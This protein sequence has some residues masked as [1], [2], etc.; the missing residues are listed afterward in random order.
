VNGLVTAWVT[1][2]VGGPMVPVALAGLAAAG[3]VLAAWPGRPV[4]ESPA[5]PRA[6]SGAPRRRLVWSVLAG[7]TGVTWI[8]GATGLVLGAALAALV[9]WWTGR[10]EPAGVR[11]A[12]ERARAELPHLVL[13]FGAALGA[14]AAPGPALEM[15]CRAF[16]GAAAARLGPV[17]AR[18]AL[19][20][21]PALVWADLGADPDLGPLGRCLARAQ[22]TGAPV[23]EAVTQL[24]RELATERRALSQ[25]R[26]RTV[27]VR[28]ALPLGGCLLPAFLL[29]G[30]VPVVAGLAGRLLAP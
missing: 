24:G 12:R 11:R 2:L 17:T 29:L 26:A 21:D 14:G 22:A 7:L 4:V 16:P 27:G 28:A 25:D 18:L 5:P 8:R 23:A 30:V 6:G 19:G 3:L 15:V 10:A 1:E 13:L 9:W 20:A